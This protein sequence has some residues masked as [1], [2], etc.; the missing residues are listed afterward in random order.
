MIFLPECFDYVGRNKEETI[1]NSHAEDD[2]YIQRYRSL[3]S[4]LDIWLSLGG[5]HEKFTG[6]KVFNSHL[7][8]DSNG[9]TR[10]KYRKLHLFDIDIPGK[11]RVKETD[12]TMP[13]NAVTPP[14]S[15]PCGVLGLSTCYD[16]RFMHLSSILRSNGAQILTYPSAFTV[17]SGMDHWE[18]SFN[19]SASIIH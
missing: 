13:G 1:K 12:I 3:A 19:S 14:V 8:I 11:V 4:E 6:T 18:V 7:I 15:T 2:D 9:Q 17:T 16:L 5:F 10:A